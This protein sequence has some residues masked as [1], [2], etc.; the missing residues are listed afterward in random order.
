MGCGRSIAFLSRPLPLLLRPTCRFFKRRRFLELLLC[1]PGRRTVHARVDVRRTE[2]GHA[3]DEQENQ[4]QALA[5]AREAGQALLQGAELE[6]SEVTEAMLGV[7]QRRACLRPGGVGI[8]AGAALESVRGFEERDPL[9]VQL[10][11]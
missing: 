9:R 7:V 11:R 6:Q 1:R 3:L 4:L 10:E 8:D 2:L 5:R